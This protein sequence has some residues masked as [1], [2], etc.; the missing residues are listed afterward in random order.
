MTQSELVEQRDISNA[1]S[2]YIRGIRQ[3]LMME[4]MLADPKV[5]ISMQAN[6]AA[7]PTAGKNGWE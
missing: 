3:E 6:I 5:K 4:D 2:I 7:L 1:I